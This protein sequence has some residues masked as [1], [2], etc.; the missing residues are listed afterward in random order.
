MD[1][2]GRDFGRLGTDKNVKWPP[3]KNKAGASPNLVEVDFP[4][5][6]RSYLRDKIR[7]KLEKW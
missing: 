5:S 4:H 7:D 6:K 2:K 3:Q 1:S